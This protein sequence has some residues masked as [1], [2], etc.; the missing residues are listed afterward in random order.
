MV[1]EV[2]SNAAKSAPTSANT[3]AV[4]SD[5]PNCNAEELAPCSSGGDSS[6]VS[7]DRVGK[8]SPMPNPANIQPPMA[9]ATDV[10]GHAADATLTTPMAIRPEPTCNTRTGVGCDMRPR[11]QEPPDQPSA[12][13]VSTMPARV[14]DKP[15]SRDII[16][17]KKTSVPKN[18]AE[19]M[20]RSAITEGRPRAT[21][22]VPAGSNR[23]AQTTSTDMATASNDTATA[24]CRWPASCSSNTPAAAP[25]AQT[26][27]RRLRVSTTSLDGV[28]SMPRRDGNTIAAAPTAMTDTDRN[29]QRQ[30]ACCTIRPLTARP[31]NAGNAY[32]AANAVKIRA[33]IAAG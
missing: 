29:T 7:T 18:A 14:G 20:P 5:P 19:A 28:G 12:P 10:A 13:S 21:Q 24:P 31:I 25:I 9:K 16:S 26:T 33:C 15:R 8:T 11:Y 1:G 3:V 32:A 17:G 4:N 30:P 6:K 27:R 23:R 2:P 22:K